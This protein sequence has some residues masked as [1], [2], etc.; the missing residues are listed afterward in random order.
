MYHPS[1]S[2]QLECN[3]V[4][5]WNFENPDTV[6]EPHD[7]PGSQEKSM[8]NVKNFLGNKLQN[9]GVIKNHC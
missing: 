1:G 6:L 5:I 8:R 3:V 4:S 9:Y 2:G 7:R